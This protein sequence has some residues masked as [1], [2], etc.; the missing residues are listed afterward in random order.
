MKIAEVP[1]RGEDAEAGPIEEGEIK[2]G[3]DRGSVG[4]GDHGRSCSPGAKVRQDQAGGTVI[5]WR[6]REGHAVRRSAGRVQDSDGRGTGVVEE[7][8]GQLDAQLP[9]RPNDLVPRESVYRYPTDFAAMSRKNLDALTRRG[10]QLAHAII[11]RYL[12]DL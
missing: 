9:N 8:V 11:D 4:D 3:R 10:E 7:V 5:G 1:K 6:D 2:V 12:A